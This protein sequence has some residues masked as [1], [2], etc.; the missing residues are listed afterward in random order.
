MHF[1]P[2][3]L[4]PSQQVSSFCL[5]FHFGQRGI[6]IC[7]VQILKLLA[8][9]NRFSWIL[10]LVKIA[11]VFIIQST[12]AGIIVKVTKGILVSHPCSSLN[13]SVSFSSW[14]IL[15]FMSLY[16]DPLKFHIIPSI[17]KEIVVPVNAVTSLFTVYKWYMN[18]KYDQRECE[19]KMR[20]K[21]E[22]NMTK[23]NVHWGDNK[24]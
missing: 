9:Q 13:I 5:A 18:R 19:Q 10:F 17:C 2:Q 21:H 23:E 3:L 7:K 14:K 24:G 4:W 15:H 6:V 20:E 1:K 11:V 22:E 8:R 12:L 16:V